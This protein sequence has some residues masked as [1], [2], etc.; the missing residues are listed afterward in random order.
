M[1]R[2]D[3]INSFKKTIC[4]KAKLYSQ[5]LE[6]F[7]FSG[8]RGGRSNN[9]TPKP[10]TV[11]GAA[12]WNRYCFRCFTHKS[13]NAKQRPHYFHAQKTR[14]YS[15][16]MLIKFEWTMFCIAK[17]NGEN[18]TVDGF[19]PQK[20]SRWFCLARSTNSITSRVVDQATTLFYFSLKS[21]KSELNARF[22]SF[23][24]SPWRILIRA[25]SEPSRTRLRGNST[26]LSGRDHWQIWTQTENPR[27]FYENNHVSK[28]QRVSK[29]CIFAGPNNPL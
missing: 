4:P 5:K 17:N 8:L 2:V 9:P 19:S 16:F 29:S 11:P 27:W 14:F 18:W 7:P 1:S 24:F 10:V 6:R 15:P 20:E 3:D 28:I 25:F 23:S 22:L 13:T 21:L 12:C 26:F